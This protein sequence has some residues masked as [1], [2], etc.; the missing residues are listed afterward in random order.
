MSLFFF[1]P[2]FFSGLALSLLIQ[3]CLY[4][5]YSYSSSVP[6]PAPE[7]GEPTSG[8]L[9][10]VLLLLLLSL[11]YPPLTHR[12]RPLDLPTYSTGR[13]VLQAAFLQRVGQP[14]A[15]IRRL[16]CVN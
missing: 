16:A 10:L 1:S 15:A 2:P 5:S 11:L 4:Y 8:P 9:H 7:A 13:E 14:D 3:A 6:L 12:F